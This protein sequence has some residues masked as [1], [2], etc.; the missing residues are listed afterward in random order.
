MQHITG[1]SC[2][3]VAHNAPAPQLKRYTYMEVLMKYALILLI[4]FSSVSCG[5]SS[6]TSQV[7]NGIIASK[8]DQR[9]STYT[10]R[11]SNGNHS[12]SVRHR[13][14][15]SGSY[16]LRKSGNKYHDITSKFGEY[17]VI[18]SSG[19][20]VYDRNGFIRKL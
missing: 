7:T 10:F 16:A 11:A 19:V 18:S 3:A 8:T 13:D 14:G 20:S 2:V 5:D 1:R 12:Y 4:I 9:G 17:F 15:S 6:N